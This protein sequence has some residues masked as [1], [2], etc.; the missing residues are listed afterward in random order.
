[1]VPIVSISRPVP[2]WNGS[3]SL[4]KGTLTESTWKMGFTVDR[5]VFLS[6]IQRTGSRVLDSSQHFLFFESSF[7]WSFASWFRFGTASNDVRLSVYLSDRMWGRTA[8]NFGRWQ[9]RMKI[10]SFVSKIAHYIKI[11][12]RILV[13]WLSKITQLHCLTF[14]FEKVYII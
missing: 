1:M 6:E 13:H 9:R 8:W 14:V 4:I 11:I 12:D 7:S 10:F 2:F 5:T 3:M